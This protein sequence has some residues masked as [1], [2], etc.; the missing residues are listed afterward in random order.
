MPIKERVVQS[1]L[2]QEIH[3]ESACKAC[4]RLKTTAIRSRMNKNYSS[5]KVNNSGGKFLKSL[6][7]YFGNPFDIGHSIIHA[8][9][10]KKDE[11]PTGKLR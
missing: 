4:K 3:G 2:T 9:I 10:P 7:N 6:D 1:S 5:V 11:P 8:R